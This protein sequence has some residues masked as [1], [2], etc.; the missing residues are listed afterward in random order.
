MPRV[1]L[2]AILWL[3]V[4]SAAAAAA[5]QTPAEG[6]D[7]RN[8]NA[9]GYGERIALGPEWLFA[10]GDDP[11]YSAADF[12]DSKWVRISAEQPLSHYGFHGIA[13]AWYRIHV[14]GLPAGIHNLTI[15]TR[16]LAGS[17]EL[18]ANGVRIGAEGP[19]SG[20]LERVQTTLATFDVPDGTIGPDGKLVVAFRFALNAAG[21]GLYG[22]SSP[23]ESDTRV[24]LMSAEEVAHESS[25]VADHKIAIHIVLVLLGLVVG[26]VAMALYTAMRESKEYLAATV[27][28]MALSGVSVVLIAQHITAVTIAGDW[29]HYAFQGIASVALIEFVR[30]I[31]KKKRTGGLV[32]LEIISFVSA[33]GS[34]L[35]RSAF[36]SFTANFA[37]YFLPTIAVDLL[38]AAM[39]VRGWMRGNTEARRLLPAVLFYSVAHYWN[40]VL[41]LAVVL[42]LTATIADPPS[43]QLMSYD[44]PLSIY[45]TYIFFIAILVFLVRRTFRVARERASSAAELEAAREVQQR[46]VL[47]P[48]EIPGFK[49]E[50]A[51][52]P[53][54]QVGGDFF[55][56]R[57]YEDKSVLVVVGDVSGKGLPAALA[58]SAIMGA[59]RAMPEL[60]PQWVLG[61]LNR[62]LC[63][64]L[65][66]G[67]V[68][69]CAVHVTPEGVM[70]VANAGHLSPYRNGKEFETEGGLPLGLSPDVEY[71][72][73][74]AKLEPGDRLMLLSDGVVEA[75]A[76]SGELLGFERTAEMATKS[77]EEIARAA[78]AFGQE[79]D[80]TVVTLKF[81]GSEGT[82]A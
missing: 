47:A 63:G 34:P 51:Y 71:A 23:M 48:R 68:T 70:T 9:S 24:Y 38:L 49:I 33:F 36:G 59:L 69:C 13:R 80:I 74:T 43:V 8:L 12:D 75:R 42:R 73:A 32:A 78:Q 39:L 54:S 52:L 20:Q 81:A 45:G 55:H 11:A 60:P 62:G 16:E 61:A 22:G 82:L 40:F 37:L 19:A 2:V 30:L 14:T 21:S 29:V 44:V 72:E 31:L 57:A 1:R 64:N 3:L 5:A 76:K 28:L 56:V 79:D 65:R 50:S 27:F 35:A 15:G 58:V 46:L 67:F 53:A 6:T 17:Y 77:A 4:A 7:P 41:Y 26:L 66:E 25:Y 18:F 10:P